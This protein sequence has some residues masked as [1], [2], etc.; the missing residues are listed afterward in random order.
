[1]LMGVEFDE[2]TRRSFD[3]IFEQVRARQLAK[4]QVSAELQDLQEE[5]RGF[6]RPR[7]EGAREDTPAGGQGRVSS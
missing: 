2:A 6:F 7:L 3:P 4:E 5:R 1:M